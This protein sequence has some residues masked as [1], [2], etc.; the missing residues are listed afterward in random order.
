MEMTPE[1]LST[2]YHA[3]FAAVVSGIEFIC[4]NV[5]K[6]REDRQGLYVVDPE[7]DFTRNRKLDLAFVLTSQ[8]CMGNM[9]LQNELLKKFNNSCEAPRASALNQRLKKVQPLC[10]Q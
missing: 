5:Q 7:R 1:W 2:I 8:L 3:I 6:Y 4:K 9:G 10:M